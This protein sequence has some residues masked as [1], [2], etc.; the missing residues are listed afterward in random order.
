MSKYLKIQE[1]KSY[2]I[3]KSKRKTKV[4]WVKDKNNIEIGLI[5][6]NTGWRKYCFYPEKFTVFDSNCLNEISGF[7]DKLNKGYKEKNE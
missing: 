6:W 2:L 7:M 4:Y 5:R 3:E 1:W